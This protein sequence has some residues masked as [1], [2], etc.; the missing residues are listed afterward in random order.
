MLVPIIVLAPACTTTAVERQREDSFFVRPSPTLIVKSDGGRI[1][2]SAGP[3][4]VI[5]VHAEFQNSSKLDYQVS[6]DGDGIV[7]EAKQVDLFRSLFLLDAPSVDLSITAPKSTYLELTTLDGDV[8][9]EGLNASGRINT[10]K[11]GIYL[12]DFSG[13]IDARTI[14]GDIEILR[15]EG[16]ATL[17]TVNG[18]VRITDG[19]GSFNVRT[20]SGDITFVGELVHGS[21]NG[22]YAAIGNVSVNLA[23]DPSLRLLATSSGSPIQNGLPMRIDGANSTGLSGIVG[24]GDAELIIQ[25]LDG[26]ISIQ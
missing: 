18:A 17:A 25:A 20:Q 23:G 2:V 15:Y 1:S 24:N 21:V 14:R 4:G 22:M 9:I 12:A 11:G 13:D 8:E 7:I 5:V 19:V 26:S 16:N 3:E 10:S 6:R